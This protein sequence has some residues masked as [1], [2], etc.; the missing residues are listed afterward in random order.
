MVIP[1]RRES[2]FGPRARNLNPLFVFGSDNIVLDAA[3]LA[4]VPVG[5][6]RSPVG[7]LR[8]QQWAIRE[9]LDTLLGSD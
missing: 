7:S 8:E 2:A 6:L 3:A 5:E 1:L 9:A 4:A